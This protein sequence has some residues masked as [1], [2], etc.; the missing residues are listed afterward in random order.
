MINLR[1]HD[2]TV[3]TI[4]TFE[5]HFYWN[6]GHNNKV[7]IFS[8]IT[9]FLIYQW[10]HLL[11]KCVLHVLNIFN[12]AHVFF[13]LTK[14]F[15]KIFT[16]SYVSLSI[17]LLSH[18]DFMTDLLQVLA[19]LNYFDTLLYLYRHPLAT[20]LPSFTKP[21]LPFRCQMCTMWMRLRNRPMKKCKCLFRWHGHFLQELESFCFLQK[22]PSFVGC[23]SSKLTVL[24]Q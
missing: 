9:T 5:Y 24:L 4:C 22:S 19:D 16:S 12:D 11:D 21:A 7:Q 1:S 20:L 3:T 17:Y 2:Y 15:N 10:I 14:S 23:S 18:Y 13:N 8:F 6:A